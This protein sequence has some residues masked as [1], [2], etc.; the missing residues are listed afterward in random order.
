MAFP[1][2]LSQLNIASYP[3]FECGSPTRRAREVA[4]WGDF[5][6]RRKLPESADIF[7]PAG[8]CQGH[9]S[10][11]TEYRSSCKTGQPR[12][13]FELQTPLPRRQGD[14]V[15]IVKPAGLP[16]GFELQ[17]AASPV[18]TAIGFL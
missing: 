5:L 1:A 14:W 4:V 6:L 3:T 18:A 7:M 12:I 11:K 15:R 17:N 8:G 2:D 16:I 13:G 9:Q 10:L